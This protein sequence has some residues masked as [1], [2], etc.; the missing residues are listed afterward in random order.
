MQKLDNILPQGIFLEALLIMEDILENHS[1]AIYSVDQYER[2]GRLV[3]CSDQL[4]NKLPKSA[5]LDE[6]GG[7]FKTV[8]SGKVYRNTEMTEGFPSMRTVFSVIISWFYLWLFTRSAQS[9]TE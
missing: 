1:I 8:K 6:I 2:F 7:L 3:A 9:S 5:V 4:R